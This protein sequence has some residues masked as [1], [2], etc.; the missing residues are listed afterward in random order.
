MKYSSV[1]ACTFHLLEVISVCLNHPAIGNFSLSLPNVTVIILYTK[2]FHNLHRD[3]VNKNKAQIIIICSLELSVLLFHDHTSVCF[4][5]CN[6]LLSICSFHRSVLQATN[7]KE[8]ENV[9]PKLKEFIF[10]LLDLNF[11]IL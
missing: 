11:L 5:N 6:H 8:I 2:T 3:N 1:L 9:L 10:Y 4:N 7:R